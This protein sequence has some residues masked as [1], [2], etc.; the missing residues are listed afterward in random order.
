[1]V[2]QT[3]HSFRFS[4]GAADLIRDWRDELCGG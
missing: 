3:P 1:M 4:G 2:R